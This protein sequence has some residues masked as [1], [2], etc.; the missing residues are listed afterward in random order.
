MVA[1]LKTR[2]AAVYWEI[3]F[4]AS[5]SVLIGKTDVLGK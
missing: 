2:R 1:V 4:E 5:M 3:A